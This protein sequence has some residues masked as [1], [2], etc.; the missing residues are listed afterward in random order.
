MF[1]DLALVD[2]NEGKIVAT[3]AGIQTDFR[4]ALICLL[5][6]AE[7][8]MPQRERI[9]IQNKVLGMQDKQPADISRYGY[10]VRSRS[11]VRDF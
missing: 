4:R 10:A 6:R 3:Y 11:E 7:G 5:V 1:Y 8:K 2:K 9:M